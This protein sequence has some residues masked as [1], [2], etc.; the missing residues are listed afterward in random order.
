MEVEMRWLKSSPKSGTWL[1]DRLLD[2]PGVYAVYG[3]GELLY[4]GS[5]SVSV[6]FRIHNG[7]C[8]GPCFNGRAA[9]PWGTYDTVIIKHSYS[10]RAGDWL[11]REYRLINRLRPWW[12][13]SGNGTGIQRGRRARIEA[14]GLGRR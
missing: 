1:G 3:D 9:T 6:L 2:R 10:R 12:N 8:I 7:H 4:V 13:Y 5:S 11:M 14:L